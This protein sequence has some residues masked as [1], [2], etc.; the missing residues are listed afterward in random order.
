M[1][2]GQVVQAPW[3]LGFCGWQGLSDGSVCS[4]DGGDLPVA[5]PVSLGGLRECQGQADSAWCLSPNKVANLI[6]VRGRRR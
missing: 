2:Q 4:A 1:G 5:F 3:S 6:P